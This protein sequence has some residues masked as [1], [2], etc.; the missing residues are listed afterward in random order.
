[1][2][3]PEKLFKEALKQENSGFFVEARAGYVHAMEA[4]NRKKFQSRK[5]RNMIAEKLNTL[6]SFI[7]Y[8]NLRSVVA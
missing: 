7:R 3:L 8:N 5:L 2:I 6:H 4:I 1:M